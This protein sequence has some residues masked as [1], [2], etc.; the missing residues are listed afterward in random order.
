MIICCDTINMPYQIVYAGE[1]VKFDYNDLH[2]Y[3]T[4]RYFGSLSNT[5]GEIYV[6]YNHMCAFTANSL[7]G[8]SVTPSYKG[9]TEKPD[10]YEINKGVLFSISEENKKWFSKK[11]EADKNIVEVK[12]PGV[13]HRPVYYC[14]SKV[15]QCTIPNLPSLDIRQI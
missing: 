8:I 4:M 6:C 11:I 2:W 12:G 15:G 9:I 7:K 5:D 3:N 10:K 1:V 13:E 14:N